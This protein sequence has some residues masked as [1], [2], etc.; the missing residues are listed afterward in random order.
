MVIIS[1]EL[2]RKKSRFNLK[3]PSL[4]CSAN[5]PMTTRVKLLG[6]NTPQSGF[7]IQSNEIFLVK[8]VEALKPLLSFIIKY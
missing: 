4:K 5:I 3:D 1:C 6:L 8:L 2:E 7:P